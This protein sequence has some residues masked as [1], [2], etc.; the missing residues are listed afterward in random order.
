LTLAELTAR[1]R[2]TFER[3]HPRSKQLHEEARESLLAGVPMAWMTM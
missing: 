3:T 2:D 1:E